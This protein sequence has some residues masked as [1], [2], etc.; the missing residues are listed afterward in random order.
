[1]PALAAAY[2]RYLRLLGIPEPPAG[3]A[4]LRDIVRRHICRV[5]F[6]NVSKLLLWNREGRGRL[7]T[8]PEFLDGLE[9]HDLGGT[10]YTNNPFL[11]GLLGALGYQADLLGADMICPNVHTCLRVRIDAAAYHVDA[12]YGAPFRDPIRLDQLPWELREGDFHYVLDH[13]P[14]G[15]G[16]EMAV[17][18]G[19]ERRHSY[20]VHGPGRSAEFFTGTVLESYDPGRTF[21]RHL[22]VCRIFERHSA[23][24]KDNVLAVHRE[25]QTTR[26]ALGSMAELEAAFADELRMPRCPIA[27]AVAILERLNGR[28]FFDAAPGTDAGMDW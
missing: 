5:P 6:E 9:F 21:M 13:N 18:A 28:P 7:T 20:T 2:V 19:L 23:D 4:G 26:T 3:L 16:Y 25:N 1:M 15:E 11:A 22:R 10:C 27:S 12:G 24:L 8:L 17:S 14:R